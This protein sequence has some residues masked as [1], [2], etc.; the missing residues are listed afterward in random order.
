MSHNWKVHMVYRHKA[1]PNHNVEF[2][3]TRCGCRLD[4]SIVKPPLADESV[5]MLT[6]TKMVTLK[7]DDMV[8]FKVME[9]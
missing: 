6:A 4:G 5:S 2:K 8:L 3:C 9:F 7:C 1:D